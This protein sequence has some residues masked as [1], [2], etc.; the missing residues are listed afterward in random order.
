MGAIPTPMDMFHLAPAPDLTPS[1][2]VLMLPP[3]DMPPTTDTMARGL[4]MPR[5]TPVSSMELMAMLVCPMLDMPP[6]EL[7]PTPMEPTPTCMVSPSD[8]ALVLTPSPRA[9]T[10][11]PRE[12][13][14]RGLLMLTPLSSMEPTD[15]LTPTPMF[16]SAPAPDLTPS[17]R[18]LMLPPRDMPPTPTDTD[19][20]DMPMESKFSL[21]RD[22]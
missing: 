22:Q 17:P 12:L 19:S 18:A 15:T 11:S 6:M 8:P 16:P 4:L 3:R 10:P 7:T 1:P 9:L 20:P 2:R 5:L 14:P 21:R 13:S